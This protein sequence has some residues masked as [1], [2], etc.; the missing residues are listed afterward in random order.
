MTEIETKAVTPVVDLRGLV[1]VAH[2][3]FRKETPSL[4]GEA[5]GLGTAAA[6]RY[7][8]SKDQKDFQDIIYNVKLQGCIVAMVEMVGSPSEVPDQ[9]LT[10]F[11]L[12]KQNLLHV[13]YDGAYNDLR[14]AT[15]RASR[16]APELTAALLDAG[17]DPMQEVV[18]HQGLVDAHLHVLQS[19]SKHFGPVIRQL[20]GA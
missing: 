19:F 10:Q 13:A 16:A 7:R 4:A 11:L 9:G 15:S 14:A 12:A 8:Q 6:H 2:H 5:K 3:A 17:A 18:I 20:N 1:L